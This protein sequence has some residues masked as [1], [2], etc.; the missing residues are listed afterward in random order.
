MGGGGGGGLWEVG[1]YLSTTVMVWIFN[2]I[3]GHVKGLVHSLWCYWSAKEPLGGGR[4]WVT[5][6]GGGAVCP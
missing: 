2:V 4:N 3:K 5:R 1:T 6:G